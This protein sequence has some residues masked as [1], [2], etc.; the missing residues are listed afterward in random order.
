MERLR[1]ENA[2]PQQILARVPA[3]LEPSSLD[4]AVSIG[5]RYC[6]IAICIARDLPGAFY[7]PSTRRWS[8]PTRSATDSAAIVDACERIER[9]LRWLSEAQRAKALIAEARIKSEALSIH[10]EEDRSRIRVPLVDPSLTE[11]KA[12]FPRA[13]R[14]VDG[15]FAVKGK[16]ATAAV[17]QWAENH[18]ENLD[19]AARSA[20][21]VDVG[22]ATI[23]RDLPQ[24]GILFV[25]RHHVILE[26]GYA[27]HWKWR[28][29]VSPLPGALRS[30][31]Y[32]L[33]RV[34]RNARSACCPSPR[35]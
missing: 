19:V 4:F 11:F 22:L 23:A 34:G 33:A 16:R 32:A 20:D 7:D 3:E 26:R 2:A 15:C 21:S 10:T 25:G 13:R 27:D 9:E 1:L 18:I 6:A 14:L 5:F 35:T 8:L 29:I 17:T 28:E 31:E 30:K 24:E 12:S